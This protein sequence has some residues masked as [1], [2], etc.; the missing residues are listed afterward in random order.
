MSNDGKFE[1]LLAEMRDHAQVLVSNLD[2]AQRAVRAL[3]NELREVGQQHDLI[4]NLY[5]QLRRIHGSLRLPD[6]VEAFNET[7]TNLVGTE[8]FALF[9]RDEG[10]GRFEKLAWIGAEAGTLQSFAEG[11]GPVG[12]AATRES[13]TYGTPVA[14]LPLIGSIRRGCVGVIAIMGLLRHKKEL[15]PRDK[16]ILEVFA[17]HAAVALEAALCAASAGNQTWKADSFRQLLGEQ[18]NIPALALNLEAAH[19]G[20][21]T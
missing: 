18:G 13:I 11:E 16:T 6:V 10:S 14:V 8:N 2:D 9:V 7:L 15:S 20:T 17:A 12:I 4:A 19:K 3:T 1:T 21:G 5:V